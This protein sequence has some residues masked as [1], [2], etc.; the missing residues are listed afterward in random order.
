M[1]TTNGNTAEQS[2]EHGLA[3][4]TVRDAG[5]NVVVPTGDDR[6][7]ASVGDERRSGQLDGGNAS[8]LS[9]IE[10]AARDPNVD[11]DKM[12]RLFQMHEQIEVRRSEQAYNASMSAAQAEMQPV[13]RNK[14][15][16]QTRSKYADLSALADAITPIYTRHGFGLS[17][18][19]KPAADGFM[20]IVA[21]VMHSAGF[22]KRYEFEMPLDIAG[23]AGK[24]NKTQ[25]WAFGSTT[26]Y[27][28]RYAKLMIF[29]LAT[30]DDDGQKAGA[31][32]TITQDQED[33]IRDL[34]ESTEADLP[35][36]AAYF[37]IEKLSDLPAAQ[38]ERAMAALNRRKS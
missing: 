34:I 10:R 13:A 25:T 27:G 8:L 11:I 32:P 12:E 37:K 1:D 16:E 36:F 31:G 29:D 19:T 20:G 38:F 18:S 35:K 24:V 4:G 28:R 14:T 6:G 33:Q 23:I 5:N 15:N 3:N 17:F 9:L 7:L 21:E 30:M 2:V 26:S 22:S